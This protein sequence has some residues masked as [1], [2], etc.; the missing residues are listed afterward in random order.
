M[1]FLRIFLLLILIVPGVVIG[2][3]ARYATGLEGL[4]ADFTFVGSMIAWNLLLVGGIFA[5]A[6]GIFDRLEMK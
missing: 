6:K 1:F 5:L 4:A 3:V 2:L